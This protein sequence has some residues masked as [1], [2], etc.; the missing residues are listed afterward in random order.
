MLTVASFIQ[1]GISLLGSAIEKVHKQKLC[2]NGASYILILKL[3]RENRTNCYAATPPTMTFHSAPA[4]RVIYGFQLSRALPTT[5]WFLD[6]HGGL[7]LREVLT[8]SCPGAEKKRL[9]R[10]S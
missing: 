5:W 1:I 3:R 4:V 2:S 7:F 9:T 10:W 8:M 6:S